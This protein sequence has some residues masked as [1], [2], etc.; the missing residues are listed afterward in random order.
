MNL[1]KNLFALSLIALSVAFVG[2]GDDADECTKTCGENQ[3]LT[4]DCECADVSNEDE[5]IEDSN[6][7]GDVTWTA[8]KVHVLAGRITV[9][10][11]ATLTIEA[12]TVIKGEAGSQAN[13]TALLVA[14]GG[15]LNANGTAALPIIFTSVADEITPEMVAAGNYSSPNLDPTI[16]GLWGGVIVC[17]YAPISAQNDND[18][19]VSEL[20][21][22]GIPTSDTNGLY[23]GSDA[24]DNS[25]SIT[26]ISIRHGGTN[27][28]SGNEINGLTL[29]GVGSG[30]TINNV[31][32]V[33]NQ[34]DG[35]EWFGGTVSVENVVVWNC[36]DDGLDTDQAWNGNCSNFIIVTPQGGSGMELDGPE[37]TYTQGTNQF[38]NG[39]IYAGDNVDHLIDWDGS[40]NTGITNV[41][42]YGIDA[43]YKA[44]EEL[45]PIES[46]GGDGAAPTNN[47]EYTLPS[48][49]TVEE[50]FTGVPASILTEVSE[51]GNTVGPDASAF[52]W[53]W[54]GHS[55]SLGNLGL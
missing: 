40:T 27:I 19:D 51:N 37:G 26:Y 20:Q 29:G 8:D 15:T 11:G 2:C 10:N 25:G 30:T 39:V 4:S 17:G 5:I 24:A 23:G 7:T 46:F 18:Q 13:A 44:T 34:D 47:W 14:R 22:E 45:D 48:G 35:I 33:A 43:D 55:G 9:E 53:T 31:E 50:I 38:D 41:Y 49:T 54:A 6:I 21:I 16:N 52:G 3:V 28:G 32:V 36:G 1:I 12:G 42:F